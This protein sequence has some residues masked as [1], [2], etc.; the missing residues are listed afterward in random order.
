MS[1]A[2]CG[3]GGAGGRG[4]ERRGVRR[5]ERVVFR[6]KERVSRVALLLPGPLLCIL[7]VPCVAERAEGGRLSP[8]NQV[9]HILCSPSLPATALPHL[10]RGPFPFSAHLTS[11]L[12]GPPHSPSQIRQPSLPRLSALSFSA[13]ALAPG[14]T[15]QH[16]LKCGVWVAHARGARSSPPCP[17]I[18]HCRTAALLHTHPTARHGVAWHGTRA[19]A[20]LCYAPPRDAAQGRSQGR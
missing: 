16:G 4:R 6:G 2:R 9:P 19:R 5:T 14:P 3:R 17:R 10:T 13:F 15:P 8:I 18:S 20:R 12:L 11:L 1:Q 7:R